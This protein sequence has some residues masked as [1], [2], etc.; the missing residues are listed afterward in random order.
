MKHL[1]YLVGS[2]T[3]MNVFYYDKVCFKLSLAIAYSSRGRTSPAQCL[4]CINRMNARWTSVQ[5]DRKYMITYPW[6]I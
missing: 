5:N 4:I 2:P 6:K 1:S 3:W